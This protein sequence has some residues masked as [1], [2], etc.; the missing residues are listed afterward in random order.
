M[1]FN[2]Q[3]L[4]QKS[5]TS[6]GQRF[7]ATKPLG[8]LRVAI[9]GAAGHVG[10][11]LSMMLKN[12]N[13]VDEL[14]LY[15]EVNTKSLALELSHIDTK[16][17]VRSTLYGNLDEA[18]EDANIVAIVASAK[19]ASDNDFPAMFKPNAMI[20]YDVMSA[21]ARMCPKALIAIA[22]NPV[23][24]IVPVACE[25]LSQRRV[26]DERKVFGITSLDVMRTNAITARLLGV[27]AERVKVPVIGG[28]S[29]K[30]VIP[31]LSRCDPPANFS[32]TE[33]MNITEH[34]Q[35]ASENLIKCKH[36]GTLS[37]SAAFAIARFIISLARALR[38]ESNIV[39]CAYV[40]SN[41]YSNVKY[42]ATPLELNLAGI[43]KNLGIPPL[44][45]YEECL[46]QNAVVMIKQDIKRGEEFA[47]GNAKEK[48]P[49]PGETGGD[50][51]ASETAI[52]CEKY[53]NSAIDVFA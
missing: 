27:K 45:E 7:L 25:M 53:S 16:C 26:F 51:G 21:V 1:M 38:N 34:V 5:V 50:M 48:R 33:L 19:G 44:S 11:P 47:H 41:L 12:S 49:A 39:E 17:K 31:V 29:D 46:L 30:T 14:Y 10:Q 4:L 20:I 24:S 8:C 43:Q 6:F 22:T 28:H 40:R 52:T 42:L 3:A 13:Y 23:N 9:I 32:V 2:G 35:T 15:D 18:L 37:M 36:A